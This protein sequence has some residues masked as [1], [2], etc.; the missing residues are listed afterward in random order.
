LV[1]HM[2]KECQSAKIFKM[3]VEQ[4]IVKLV[5]V[6]DESQLDKCVILEHFVRKGLGLYDDEPN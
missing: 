6:E 4:I 1:C 2:I 5:Q 3:I